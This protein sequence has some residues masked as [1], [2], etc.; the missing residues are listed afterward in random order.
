MIDRFVYDICCTM[1]YVV[2]NMGCYGYASVLYVKF[3]YIY[4]VYVYIYI[5]IIYFN[6][7]YIH[8]ALLRCSNLVS[9]CA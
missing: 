9:L 4:T 3:I 2:Y 7:F 1:W 5:C 6:L 8:S